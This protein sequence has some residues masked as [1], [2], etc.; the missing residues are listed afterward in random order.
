MRRLGLRLFRV[1]AIGLA[2]W[3]AYHYLAPRGLAWVVWAG[4]G[5]L[6][7]G[8][9]AWRTVTIVRARARARQEERWADALVDAP[10]RPAAIRDLRAALASERHPSERVHLTLVLAELLEADGEPAAALEALDALDLAAQ[11]ERARA[12]V[13]H[14]CAVAA[15]SAGD[16]ERAERALAPGP[17][18]ERTLDTKIELLRAVLA[19]ERGDAERALAI[20]E[21]ERKAQDDELQI[22][23][24]VVRALAVD[25]LGDH[26]DALKILRGLGDDMLAVLALLGLPRVRRLAAEAR[27]EG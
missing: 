4:V 27:D 20:A 16:L 10:R 22:E 6:A 2:A 7:L 3:V 9:I 11:P 24:K 17:I 23:A 19:I 13:R 5:T 14:A 1:V 25:A 8:W 18:G 21:R 26:E 12:V 15:L